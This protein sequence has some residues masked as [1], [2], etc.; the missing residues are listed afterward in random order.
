MSSFSASSSHLQSEN[1]LCVVDTTTNTIISYA[2]WV[3]LPKGYDASEDPDTLQPPPPPEANEALICD[4]ARMTGELRSAD[5]GRKEAHWLLAV[6]AT[7][8]EHQGRGAGSMLIEWAFP[9][10]D[11]MGVRC[12]VDSSAAGH[13][14]YQRKGFKEAAGVIDLNLGRQDDVYLAVASRAEGLGSNGPPNLRPSATTTIYREAIA[15]A[16]G[17]ALDVEILKPCDVQGIGASIGHEHVWWR[18]KRKGANSVEIGW[19]NKVESH[20]STM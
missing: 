12:Y 14:L 2:V 4:F 11:E 1:F 13:S 9:K 5:P 19:K 18:V 7:H 10:A 3:Y 15:K 8:S 6:L 20:Y 17:I 16:F